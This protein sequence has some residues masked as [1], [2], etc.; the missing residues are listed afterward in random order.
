M[1]LKS[2]HLLVSSRFTASSSRRPQ[3]QRCAL[4]SRP[5]TRVPS[6]PAAGRGGHADPG[7]LFQLRR[8]A[9]GTCSH[10]G[11]LACAALFRPPGPWSAS[12]T[13][14]CGL[15]QLPCR[16]W[17]WPGEPGATQWP[18]SLPWAALVYQAPTTCLAFH[19]DWNC[20]AGKRSVR[21]LHG[22]RDAEGA[23]HG[24]AACAC[25]CTHAH[26]CTHCGC[27]TCPAS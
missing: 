4:R 10:S 22:A 17:Q 26:A 21:E 14:S 24:G 6:V 16:R 11:T 20:T 18:H 25:V 7:G 12:N 2:E 13:G 19:S 9:G 27:D 3:G 1:D 15:E 5:L 8:R 23:R